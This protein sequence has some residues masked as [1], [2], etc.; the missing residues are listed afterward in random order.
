MARRIDIEL[1][2]KRPDGSWTWRAP[3][4][5]QPRGEVQPGLVPA[6]AKV[7]DILRADAEFE[8]EGIVITALSAPKAT[9]AGDDEARRIEIIGSGRSTPAGVS[10]VL[11]PGGRRRWEDEGGRQRSRRR[12]TGE[13]ADEGGAKQ[14]RAASATAG[15]P[16]DRRRPSGGERAGRGERTGGERG[17]RGERTDGERGGRARRSEEAAGERPRRRP[18]AGPARPRPGRP[19]AGT[20]PERGRPR[21]LQPAATFRNEVLAELRP[22]QLPVAEQLLRGGIPALRAAI[23]EQ[24]ARAKAEGRDQVP[25]E[26]LLAMADELLPKVNLAV[27]KDRATAVRDAGREAPLRE[28]RSV[29]AGAS[30]V[31]LDEEGRSLLGALRQSLDERVTA[32]RQ[33]WLGRITGALDDSRLPEAL[34]VASRPPEPAARIPAELAVRLAADAGAALSP[35]VS[36]EQ[37]LALLDAVVAS[38]VRRTVKPVGLPQPPSERLLQA[39]H[40]SAGLVPELARLLGLPIPPPPRRPATSGARRG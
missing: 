39:V 3:G 30:A 32:L 17:E 22:E 7:G 40:R 14:G 26:P 21:R 4:A 20:R 27:W 38:P 33:A 31:A 5:R 19:E 34:Q 23:E 36:E 29:V 28:V 13:D 1:T 25:P 8:L 24:N 15:R 9:A 18:A 35:E 10:V 37:W 12:P 16:E 11:A 2:S 6:E